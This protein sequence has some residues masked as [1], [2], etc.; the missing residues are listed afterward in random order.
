M[1][2][3]SGGP[4]KTV[5][6]MLVRRKI[7]ATTVYRIPYVKYNLNLL[8]NLKTAPS[9]LPGKLVDAQ[10]QMILSLIFSSPLFIRGR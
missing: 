4:K 8:L 2:V 6:S 5:C 9:R 10:P 1:Y 3:G 7:K